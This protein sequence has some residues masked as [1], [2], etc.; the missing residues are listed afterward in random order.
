MTVANQPPVE[1]V[2]RPDRDAVH[3]LTLDLLAWI[4]NA[5]RCY[6]ETMDAWRTGC[7][8]FPIWEDA[9]DDGLVALERTPGVPADQMPVI[10][11]PRGHLLL[12]CHATMTPLRARGGDQ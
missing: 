4:A 7:P 8:K 2:T 5:P 12:A 3:P 11:T 9:L 10:L 6:A 1:V